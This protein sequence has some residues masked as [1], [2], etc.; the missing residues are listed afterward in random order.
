MKIPYLPPNLQN[1]KFHQIHLKGKYS[2]GFRSDKGKY[3][4]KNI[5]LK[6]SELVTYSNAT[7]SHL[8]TIIN[9]STL[10]FGLAPFG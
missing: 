9:R 2:G 10:S 6:S 7:T 3:I 1:T 8:L 5:E 4:L